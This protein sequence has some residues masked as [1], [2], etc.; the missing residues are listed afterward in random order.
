VIKPGTQ[1]NEMVAHNDWLP[2]LL[3]AA[4][5]PNVKEKLLKGYKAATKLSRS[6]WMATICV[7]LRADPYERGPN[8]SGM[9]IRWYGDLL[10]LF[11]L[12]QQKLKEFFAD[13]MKYPYQVGSSLTVSNI[14]YQTLKVAEAMKRLSQVEELAPQT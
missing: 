8:E 2:T 12:V 6:I 11:V 13:F 4:G 3:A 7:N 9:Y 14:N 1:I 10:W 5:E